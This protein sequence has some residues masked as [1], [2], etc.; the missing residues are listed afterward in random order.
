MT[1]KQEL[2]EAKTGIKSDDVT[3][4]MIDAFRK[5][6]DLDRCADVTERP[7]WHSWAI[8]YTD[9]FTLCESAWKRYE[10]DRMDEKVGE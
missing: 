10:A 6:C 8:A 2:W 4:K 7:T 3:D 5:H 9:G 1:K